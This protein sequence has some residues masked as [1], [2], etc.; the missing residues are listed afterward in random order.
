[1]SNT[2]N[3]LKNNTCFYLAVFDPIKLFSLSEMY[4]QI[5]L[6]LQM[7]T[8]GAQDAS[9][10]SVQEDVEHKYILQDLELVLLI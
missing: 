9:T 5:T 3:V 8:S 1:M 4:V 6:Y 2:L 7:S 10:F